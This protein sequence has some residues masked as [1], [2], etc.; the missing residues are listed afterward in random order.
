MK[1]LLLL[2]G[3]GL[4]L[5]GCQEKGNISSVSGEYN[6][7]LKDK[8]P[9]FYPYSNTMDSLIQYHSFEWNEDL[10]YPSFPSEWYF[11]T[12]K[13]EYEE[14]FKDFPG[15]NPFLYSDDFFETYSLVGKFNCIRN[16]ATSN[17]EV[18]FGIHEVDKKEN[19]ITLTIYQSIIGYVS[20][21]Y[22]NNYLLLGFLD[23]GKNQNCTYQTEI[24][25]NFYYTDEMLQTPR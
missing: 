11:I 17:Q 21:N 14:I 25:Y 6:V 8:E 13:E 9:T 2:L 10:S 23:P 24:V 5:T 19:Q 3:I 20:N 4:L 16:Y 1:K 22:K 12:T 18:M 7:H 15:G